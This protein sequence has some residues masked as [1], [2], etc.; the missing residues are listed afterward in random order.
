MINVITTSLALIAILAQADANSGTPEAKTAAQ[1]LLSQ[2]SSSS[3]RGI[4]RPLSTTSTKP[5]LPT[6][7]QATLQYRPD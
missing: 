1:A 3:A 5:I 7:A 2:V 6:P 4:S